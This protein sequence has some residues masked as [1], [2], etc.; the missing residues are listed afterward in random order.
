MPTSSRQP[1]SVGILIA[2]AYIVAVLTTADYPRRIWAG[3]A[4]VGLADTYR[5]TLVA[6]AGP[7]LLAG[8]LLLSRSS[9]TSR[10]A[11]GVWG[12]MTTNLLFEFISVLGSAAPL[13]GLVLYVARDAAL[14]LLLTALIRGRSRRPSSWI[15]VT[16]I[17]VALLQAVIALVQGLSALPT[18]SAWLAERWSFATL[19]EGERAQGLTAYP[20]LL[21]ALIATIAPLVALTFARKWLWVSIW[22]LMCA[23]VLASGARA[24][25]LAMA[26]G[27]AVAVVVATTA[28]TTRSRR[29]LIL[30]VL[31]TALVGAVIGW[32]PDV[33]MR[34]GGTGGPERITTQEIAWELWHQNPWWGAG[35][36][37][38]SFAARQLPDYASW[39]SRIVPVHNWLLL[40]L[41][42]GGTAGGITAVLL[43]LG[44]VLWLLL[45]GSGHKDAVLAASFTALAV[46]QWF[47][48]EM[49]YWLGGAVIQILLLALW[50]GPWHPAPPRTQPSL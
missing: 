22:V 23:A 42:E 6:G 11:M 38:F 32:Q 29:T 20:T 44:P 28:P 4:P 46:S 24:S 12:V 45:R 19:A 36:G 30:V 7:P 47:D 18:G 3:D 35:S 41:A 34:L 16:L 37:N 21:G 31:T 50:V 40:R 43:W 8:L 48:Y 14:W 5:W 26:A 33:L 1:T 49:L 39:Q 15:L 9:W 10:L 17:G 25:G 2:V 13:R 27:L